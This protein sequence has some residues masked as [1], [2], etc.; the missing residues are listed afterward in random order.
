MYLSATEE[1]NGLTDIKFGMNPPYIPK[2]GRYN[3][4][5]TWMHSDQNAYFEKINMI[6]VAQNAKV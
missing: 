1:E 5:P 2:M 4:N 3:T 6:K